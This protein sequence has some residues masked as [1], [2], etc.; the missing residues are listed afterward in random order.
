LRSELDLVFLMT[1]RGGLLDAD[2]AAELE[3]PEAQG[4]AGSRLSPPRRAAG[5]DKLLES[6]LGHEQGGVIAELCPV[7]SWW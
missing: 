4:G 6:S 3:A 5:G 2:L 7:L 1:T